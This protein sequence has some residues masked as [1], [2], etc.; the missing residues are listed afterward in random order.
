M[1]HAIEIL[2]SSPGMAH[3]PLDRDECLVS[4]ICASVGHELHNASLATKVGE[5]PECVLDVSKAIFAWDGLS[6]HLHGFPSHQ[7]VAMPTWGAF[8]MRSSLGTPAP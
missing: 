8:F 2:H 5:D 7:I 4:N 6:T 3:E 1:F